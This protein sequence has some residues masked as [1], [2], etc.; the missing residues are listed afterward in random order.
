ML[1]ESSSN[2]LLWIQLFPILSCWSCEH[3]RK[4]INVST[5]PFLCKDSFAVAAC[6]HRLPILLHISV[7]VVFSSKNIVHAYDWDPSVAGRNR[8]RGGG[9]AIYGP[10]KYVPLWRVWFSSSLLWH[11]VYKSER[12]ATSFPGSLFSASIVV[13]TI[14]VEKRDPGNEVERLG[15]E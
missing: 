1:F 5:I 13:T 14:E 11:R 2:F 6:T 12:L 10:Y 9:T 3:L 15:L 4:S 7:T 8:T